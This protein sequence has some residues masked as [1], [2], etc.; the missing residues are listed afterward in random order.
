LSGGPGT[1]RRTVA[2]RPLKRMITAEVAS[3]FSSQYPPQSV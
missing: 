2:R 1:A 3:R